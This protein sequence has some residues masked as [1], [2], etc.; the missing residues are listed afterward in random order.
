MG[1][2]NRAG[3]QIA[4][5]HEVA[6]ARGL[7]PFVSSHSH[8]NLIDRR[9]ELEVVP[10]AINYNLGIFPYFPLA[11]GLLTGKYTDGKAP[12]GSRLSRGDKL[13]QADLEQL[14]KLRELAHDIDASKSA[15]AIA[16]LALRPQVA[17]VIAGATKPEQIEANAAALDVELTVET[18]Q[19][20]DEIFPSPAKVALF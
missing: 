5:A 14:K 17:S 1:H 19:R 8:Y 2:F 9:A 20:L 13:A 16:W 15:I 18:L 4:E 6:K 11:S 12:R 3:W 10:A 7:T